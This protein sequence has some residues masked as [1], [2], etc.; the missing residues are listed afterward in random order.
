MKILFFTTKKKKKTGN[1][2]NSDISP[3]SRRGDLCKLSYFYPFLS[4][5]ADVT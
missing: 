1:L 4:I 3:K 2:S 5:K